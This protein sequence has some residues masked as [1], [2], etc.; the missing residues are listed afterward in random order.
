L[1]TGRQARRD[2]EGYPGKGRVGLTQKTSMQKRKRAR[3]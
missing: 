2:V 3:E 1:S